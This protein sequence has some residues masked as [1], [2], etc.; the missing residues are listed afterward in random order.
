M[1]GAEYPFCNT[2][3]TTLKTVIR[4][5][6]GLLLIKDGTVIR[7]WSHNRL[8]DDSQLTLPLEKSE[9]GQMPQ[10]SVPGKIVNLLLWFVLPLVLLTIADRMWMWTKW[11]RRKRKTRK[12][13]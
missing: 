12:N 11:V 2:D 5:N 9:L 10:D 8:P 13:H 7:K 3:E 1:T 6:P 4:S